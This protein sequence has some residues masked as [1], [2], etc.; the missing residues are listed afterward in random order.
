MKYIGEKKVKIEE[1]FSP[2]YGC[3]LK[4]THCVEYVKELMDNP[5]IEV[6]KSKMYK[7]LLGHLEREGEVW[8]LKDKP[9]LRQSVENM[10]GLIASIRE[11]G[12]LKYEEEDYRIQGDQPRGSVLGYIKD[13]VF[14]IWDGHHRT[15]ILYL[16]GEKYMSV[17]VY[18]KKP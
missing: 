10:K 17:R 11:H 14:N 5:N 16:L 6:T 2:F 18:E 12:F 9:A 15:S 13:G 4:D 3:K 1:I 7:F 8:G